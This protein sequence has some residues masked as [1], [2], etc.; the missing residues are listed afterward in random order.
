[1]SY[2][3]Q[4]CVSVFSANFLQGHVWFH[5]SF[6][7]RNVGSINRGWDELAKWGGWALPSAEQWGNAGATLTDGE[8]A[9]CSSSERPKRVVPVNIE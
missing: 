1:M 7:T 9:P 3:L 6:R 5:F 2:R 8:N 4:N